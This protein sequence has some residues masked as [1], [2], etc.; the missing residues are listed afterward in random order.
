VTWS[1]SAEQQG[2]EPDPA[3]FTGDVEVR[4]RPEHVE[5]AR[6]VQRALHL[7]VGIKACT[8]W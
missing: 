4:E 2:R 5:L 7:G 3:E 6:A 1:K 8:G